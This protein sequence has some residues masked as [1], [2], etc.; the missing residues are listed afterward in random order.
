MSISN[1]RAPRT[2]DLNRT[3]QTIYDDIND[4][5]NSVNQDV[6]QSIEGK[7]KEGDI[8]V[9]QDSSSKYSTTKH[10]LEFRT[11]EGWDKAVT[12]PRNPDNY[13]MMAYNKD[14]ETFEWVN[15]DNALSIE[16]GSP[17]TAAIASSALGSSGVIIDATPSE[18]GSGKGVLVVGTTN[19]EPINR[20]RTKNVTGDVDFSTSGSNVV[21]TVEQASG[22]LILPSEDA[23]GV[24]TNKIYN[25]NGT[26]KFNGAAIGGAGGGDAFKHIEIAGQTTVTAQEAADTLTFSA[27]TGMSFATNNETI[28]FNSTDTI[29][30]VQDVNNST[31]YSN[32]TQ[33]NFENAAITNPG[34]GATLQINTRVNFGTD[35]VSQYWDSNN[36]ELMP[37]I[38]D[39]YVQDTGDGSS[40][41]PKVHIRTATDRSFLIRTNNYQKSS[42]PIP[43]P[44]PRCTHVYFTQT[45]GGASYDPGQIAIGQSQSLFAKVQYSEV[46]GTIDSGTP[47]VRFR[48][49]NANTNTNSTAEIDLSSESNHLHSN[50]SSAVGASSNTNP[51]LR[52]GYTELSDIMTECFETIDGQS[53][54]VDADAT[55]KKI[56]F[57]NYRICGASSQ[58]PSDVIISNESLN[59]ET[60]NTSNIYNQWTQQAITCPNLGYIW[61]GIPIGV[62]GTHTTP[63]ITEIRSDNGNSPGDNVVGNFNVT[64]LNYTNPHGAVEQYK[65][66]YSNPQAPH[67][68]NW[69]TS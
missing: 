45:L 42:E 68:T 35:S 48:T 51:S 29:P 61:F 15:T 9:I 55:H 44:D 24:T 11:D 57:R 31:D 39:I 41:Y 4:I 65:I 1:K 20:L 47:K 43:D 6:S 10:K 52:D 30:D 59:N 13:A 18:N 25:E 53:W 27:G 19:E 60:L 16:F 7:G 22:G 58:P 2:G 8:R 26:L 56:Y 63:D 38:G 28:T 67:T 54:S 69:W 34:G 33:F 66:W 50:A 21:V 46:T 12:M 40:S 5:I 32:V 37:N 62:T 3:I 64:I 17:G 14:S 23:P 49:Y 36:D